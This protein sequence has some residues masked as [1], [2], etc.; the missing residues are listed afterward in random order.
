V[1]DP[2]HG[3]EEIGS[4]HNG[5][6]EKDSNLDMALRVEKLLIER[7]YDVLLTRRSDT[8]A[9]A[10]APGFTATRS[11]IQARID[12]ANAADADVFVSIHSNGSTDPGQRGVEVWYDS[13]RSFGL[14][15]LRL[16]SLLKRHVLSELVTFGY[17]AHDRGLFDGR[18]FR[19]RGERCFSLF[20]LGG[21]RE[22][23]RA[24]IERRGGDPD[25]LGV[26]EGAPIHSR[27]AVM[28]G[29]L[30][31]LLIITN[32]AD[33]A[34]LRDEGARHALARGLADALVEFLSTRQGG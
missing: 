24:E 5:V 8:R 10:Q 32:P 18:C 14:E 31:E 25:A 7:G 20:V 17:A 16:A 3:G 33:A 21:P 15:N 13:S 28:P 4:A 11:D 27:P 30:V 23:S 26:T 29:A 2:G 9:A 12:M 22:T 34:V 19:Q 6:V 1:L